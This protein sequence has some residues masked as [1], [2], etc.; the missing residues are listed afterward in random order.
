MRLALYICVFIGMCSCSG[1]GSPGTLIPSDVAADSVIVPPEVQASYAQLE[2]EI[3][4]FDL[5]NYELVNNPHTA[6]QQPL[7][8]RR[9]LLFTNFQDQ[10]SDSSLYVMTLPSEEGANDALIEQ[11]ARQFGFRVT[12]RFYYGGFWEIS[13]YYYRMSDYE[14][15]SDVALSVGE[16]GWVADWLL[17]H[18][19]DRVF[20]VGPSGD[21]D[22]VLP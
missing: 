3:A 9:A 16:L 19:P 5:H 11:F 18:Y 4:T 13:D 21:T 15:R 2:A 7:S 1:A 8:M 12:S 14:L 20:T 6:P 10:A 17:S 22:I